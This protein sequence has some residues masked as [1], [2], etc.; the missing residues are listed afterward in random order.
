MTAAVPELWPAWWEEHP[1]GA[2]AFAALRPLLR[3]QLLD[4]P[5]YAIAHRQLMIRFMHPVTVPGPGD[6][7]NAIGEL[8]EHLDAAN[9]AGDV[10][11][12]R[13]TDAARMLNVS[14]DRAHLLAPFDREEDAE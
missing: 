12:A 13:L 10:D 11:V 6:F 8:F 1:H 2:G 3:C 14:M 9:Q 4:L 7:A 5:G